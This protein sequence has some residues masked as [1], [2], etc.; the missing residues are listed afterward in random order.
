MNTKKRHREKARWEPHKNTAD[1][2]EKCPGSSTSQNS[3]RTAIC[4]PSNKLSKED[5][6]DMHGTAG[7]TRTNS[8]NVLLWTLVHRHASVGWP[9]KTNLHQFCVDTGFKLEK[10]PEWWMIGMDGK[11]ES[12]NYMLSAW[13]D[14]YDNN[15]AKGIFMGDFLILN[16]PNE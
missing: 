6:Q 7:E 5:K 14:D 4:F 9:L 8:C 1:T 3:S 15:I 12:G 2:L 13:N 16:W 11:R 10:Q